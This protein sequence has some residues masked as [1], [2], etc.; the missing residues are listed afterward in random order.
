MDKGWDEKNHSLTAM[1]NGLVR[2][3]ITIILTQ[4]SYSYMK[5]MQA[6]LLSA[7]II[8]CCIKGPYDNYGGSGKVKKNA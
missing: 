1:R 8:K 3:L 2:N 4:R 5:K 6:M 7:I